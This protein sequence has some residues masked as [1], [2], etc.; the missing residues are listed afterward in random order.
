MGISRPASSRKK[1]VNLSI[2]GELLSG[3]RAQ[4][5]NLSAI[6]EQALSREQARLWLAENGSAIEVYNEDIRQNGIWSDGIRDW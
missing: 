5:L 6:L 4:G 1:A 2:D 3:A